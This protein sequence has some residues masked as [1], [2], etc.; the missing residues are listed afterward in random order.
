[1]TKFFF[2]R[3]QYNGDLRV[4]L[5]LIHEIQEDTRKEKKKQRLNL[6]WCK[7]EDRKDKHDGK[8][9]PNW[10]DSYCV[11]DSLQNKAYSKELNEKLI[12]RMWNVTR[13]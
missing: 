8:L 10:D 11:V 7:L 5:N 2:F 1:M 12:S 13:A 4:E 6:M 9:V 3:A